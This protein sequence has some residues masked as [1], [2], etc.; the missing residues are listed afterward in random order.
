MNSQSMKAE[1]RE[2]VSNIL[3]MYFEGLTTE[4]ESHTALDKLQVRGGFG[5]N[6]Y[7]GY[8]YQVQ[9][10]VDFEYHTPVRGT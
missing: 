1:K 3:S 7:V 4:E 9:A 10:W 6:R 8:D 2:T 5:D